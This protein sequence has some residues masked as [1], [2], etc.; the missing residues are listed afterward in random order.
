MQAVSIQKNPLRA[1]NND[2]KKEASGPELESF[3]AIVS[4]FCN[5]PI[6]FLCASPTELSDHKNTF[7]GHNVK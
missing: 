1:L 7:V 3:V 4:G 5:T 6:H 2:T